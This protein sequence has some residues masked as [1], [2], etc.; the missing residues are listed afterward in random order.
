MKSAVIGELHA[1]RGSGKQAA[2]WPQ[3]RIFASVG[4]ALTALNSRVTEA[5]RAQ[6]TFEELNA[7]SDHDLEDIGI[8]RA[9]V[10]A[11]VAGVYRD[12][13]PATSNVITLDRPHK[14]QSPEAAEAPSKRS[15]N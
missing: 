6:R 7:M 5:R 8:S 14:F 11:I 9:N 4:R 3:A 12:A 13:R 1:S 10:P 15:S 2:Q